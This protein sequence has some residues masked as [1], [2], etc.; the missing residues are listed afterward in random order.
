MIQE[1]AEERSLNYL[2]LRE[3][4]SGARRSLNFPDSRKPFKKPVSIFDEITN[5]KKVLFAYNFR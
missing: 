3:F 2:D 4:T 1:S 5:L